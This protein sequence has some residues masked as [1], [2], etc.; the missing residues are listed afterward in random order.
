MANAEELIIN[1]KAVMDINDIKSNVNQIQNVLSKL[2]LP[3]DLGKGL[4]KNIE[5]VGAETEKAAQLM[6]KGFTKASDVSSLDKSLKAIDEAYKAILQDVGKI[7]NDTLQKALTF[8]TGPIADLQKQWDKLK[9][10]FDEKIQTSG[11][12]E[13]KKQ[14]TDINTVSKSKQFGEFLKQF[15]AGNIE[16]ATAA[17]QN[18][19]ANMK[20]F[21]NETFRNSAG[22]TDFIT[23]ID[24]LTASLSKG[25]LNTASTQLKTLIDSTSNIPAGNEKI[26]TYAEAIQNLLNHLKQLSSGDVG[27]NQIINDLQEI[28]TSILTMKSDQI[29]KVATS[30]H[31]VGNSAEASSAQV[32]TLSQSLLETAKSQADLNGQINQLA[33]RALHFTSLV[34]GVQLFKKAIKEAYDEVKTLDKAMT[35]TAVVTNFSVG[36]MW[37]KLPEYT[38]VANKYGAAI[39]DAYDVMTI[40]YQ[41]GLDTNQAFALGEQTMQMARIAGLDYANAADKMTN[42]LRGFN[43][44]LNETSAQR[45]NDV[46]S[47]L[48]AISA[49]DTKELATAMTKVA[50]LA[51]SANMEFENTAAFLAQ[52]IETT[53]ESA[54]TAGTALKTVVARF[55]EVKELYSEGDLIGDVDGEE[56]NINKV[57][58]AL[59][60]AGIDL[61][62]FMTGAK[63]LDDILLELSGKWDSLDLLTQRY[64]ATMAAGSRQQSRFLALM[65]DNARL[66]E[67]TSAA[68]N[69]QGASAEQFAKTQ[70]SLE[71]KLNKLKN[72][73]DEFVMGLANAGVFKK[74]IDL[75]TSLLT[76][77]NN[78]LASFEKWEVLVASLE[79]LRV[80]D[81]Q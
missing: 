73:W 13:V 61:N 2:K 79:V 32:K 47:E 71:T 78:I 8:D 51:N 36:D 27:L 66:T 11:L 41:Q 68:Y 74:I 6:E 80:Q 31:N 17:L 23:N 52:M 69:A 46:Y 75:L 40:F 34:N 76:H 24:N 81:Y 16:G 67:L 64:I 39:K 48:A 58:E 22:F 62:E 7:D 10:S 70:E 55:A 42:A 43:M 77:I 45:V 44:E 4:S 26:K 1:L 53:R 25:D 35:E 33:S 15:Q 59:R 28:G 54:E 30:M 5:K 37:E 50:S 63:G 49:S 60:S 9:A 21:G 56:V 19:S 72:A 20:S 57:G 18:L 29:D 3:E 14:V 38:D 65:S 12:E